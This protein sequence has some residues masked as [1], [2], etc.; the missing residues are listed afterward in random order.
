MP[1]HQTAFIRQ[2]ALEKAREIKVKADEEFAIEKVSPSINLT[3]SAHARTSIARAL[4][5]L[6]S[7]SGPM[8]ELSPHCHSLGDIASAQAFILD[9]NLP[10]TGADPGVFPLARSRTGQDCPTGD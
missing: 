4:A 6:W 2:E 7:E 10:R 8:T 9:R 5:L 1:L 3:S